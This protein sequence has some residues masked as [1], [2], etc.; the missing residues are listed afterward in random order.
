MNVGLSFGEI[1]EGGEEIGVNR[2][3][4]WVE[5]Q[6]RRWEVSDTRHTGNPVPV[7]F[8]RGH[9]CINPQYS[10]PSPSRITPVRLP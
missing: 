10:Y 3:D 5:R 2:D 7:D 8:R 1:T 9:W 6:P 4:L